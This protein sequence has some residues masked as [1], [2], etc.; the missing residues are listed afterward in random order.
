MNL[1]EI[2]EMIQLMNE[3]NLSELEMEEDGLKIRLKNWLKNKRRVNEEFPENLRLA[4][5]GN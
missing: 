3:N 2:K 5:V 4:L 1:K